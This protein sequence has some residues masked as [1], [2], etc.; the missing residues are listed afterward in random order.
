[1]KTKFLFPGGEG[2]NSEWILGREETV[3]ELHS[4]PLVLQWRM[5]VNKFINRK[6][7]I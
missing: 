1:M 5:T 2:K 7:K 4:Y 3:P 6:D